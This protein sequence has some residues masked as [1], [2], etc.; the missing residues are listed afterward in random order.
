MS[1][2]IGGDIAVPGDKSLSHRALMFAAAARGESRLN[3]LLPGEDCRSTAAVLRALGADIPEL[4]GDGSEIRVRSAGIRS[5]TA[6]RT[7]LD[8]GNSGTTARLMMGLLAGRPFCSTL[9]GD[10]S[11]RGRPMRRVTDPLSKMGTSVRELD[12][13][14]RLPLEICG[15]ELRPLD[16]RSPKASAQIKSAILLAGLSGVVDV[17]VWEPIR[18][19]DHTERMLLALGVDLDQGPADGGWRV[20]TRASER[21]R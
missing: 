15:G 10:A 20:A 3:G 18:S 9:T 7:I 13:A 16:Y 17:S 8:C 12:T 14:D 11:L 2:E 4:P 5:W 21:C 1:F 6:P 19:R